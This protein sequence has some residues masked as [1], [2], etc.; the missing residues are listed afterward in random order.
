MASDK[1]FAERTSELVDAAIAFVVGNAKDVPNRIIFY[2][3]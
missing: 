1:F 3:K 2:L